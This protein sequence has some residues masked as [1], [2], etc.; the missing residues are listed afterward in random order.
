MHLLF[1]LILCSVLSCCH[2]KSTTVSPIGFYRYNY[3]QKTGEAGWS[4]KNYQKVLFIREDSTYKLVH[5]SPNEGFEIL[6][7]SGKWHFENNRIHFS[8]IADTSWKSSNFKY[9]S[10]KIHENHLV[11]H[12]LQFL[13]VIK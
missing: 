4:Y 2:T 8:S 6:P 11:I 12:G 9:F 5:L 7:D 3:C 1:I 13:K 10:S